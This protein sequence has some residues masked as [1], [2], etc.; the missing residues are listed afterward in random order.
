[1][2]VRLCARTSSG[3]ALSSTQDDTSEK[4]VEAPPKVSESMLCPPTEREEPQTGALPRLSRLWI[5]SELGARGD[6]PTT[7]T[8]PPSELGSIPSWSSSASPHGDNSLDLARLVVRGIVSEGASGT[9]Y[10]VHDTVQERDATMKVVRLSRSLATE[11]RLLRKLSRDPHGFLLTPYTGASRH[12]WQS[13]SGDLHILTEY[14]AGGTLEAYLGSLS[15]REVW[16]VT[17]ELILGLSWLHAHQ[18]IH[19]ALSPAN[20]L[21]GGDGHCAIAGLDSCRRV[22]R[23]RKLQSDGLDFALA[24]TAPELQVQGAE[25]DEKVDVWSLGVTVSEL[26]TGKLFAMTGD[27]VRSQTAFEEM[28]GVASR[29]MQRAER[30]CGYLVSL[31]EDMLEVDPE[32]RKSLSEISLDPGFRHMG[33][34]WEDVLS[35]R[36]IGR[37]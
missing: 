37:V 19:H 17:A 7:S 5:P 12:E 27:G 18:Y 29:R 25:Y 33:I 11:V 10:L 34:C 26:L 16:L 13:A 30:A 36:E 4:H 2:G 9:V 24:M 32:R 23:G 15:H 28:C 3:R 31:T 35:E 14:Y 6:L 22:G 21:V 20:I 8:E 1:M